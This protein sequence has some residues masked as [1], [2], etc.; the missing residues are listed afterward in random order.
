M[1]ISSDDQF[2]FQRLVTLAPFV[3]IGHAECRDLESRGPGPLAATI[4]TRLKAADSTELCWLALAVLGAYFPEDN[5][6]VALQ[7]SLRL[8]EPGLT[9]RALLGA[10][11]RQQHRLSKPARVVKVVTD[12]VIVDVDFCARYLHNTGIQRVVRQTMRRWLAQ[13]RDITLVAWLPHARAYRYLAPQERER[14]INWGSPAAMEPNSSQDLGDGDDVIIPFRCT[15]IVPEVPQQI[16][17]AP[18]RSLAK[19]SGNRCHLIAYD[20]IPVVSATTVPADETTRFLDY[21]SF[22]KHAHLAVAISEATA[23]EFRG[24]T[25]ALAPQGLEG[26]EVVA[27]SLP[28]ARPDTSGHGPTATM[29]KP[30]VLCVGSIEPRKNQFA[31]L[32]ASEQLWAQGVSF[33]LMFIG[34]GSTQPVAALERAL[35]KARRRGHDVALLSGVADAELE[36]AYRSATLTVFPS[37]HE[38]YGL[39]V[40]ESLAYGVPVV[41]SNFGATAEVAKNGGCVLVD[42]RD[43]AAIAAAMFDILTNESLR[44]E[45]IGGIGALPTR[46]WDDYATAAWTALAHHAGPVSHG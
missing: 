29:D 25:S 2:F 30:I 16:L 3:G 40:A 20:M 44:A 18:L 45:L 33:R 10:L 21:L 6:V 11:V 36:S 1:E 13:G 15:V 17:C 43:D 4:A 7:R 26:P 9:H 41:T 22:V 39:P 23:E 42:P 31:V 38:G 46:D 28:M 34:G 35:A 14:V 8:A 19:N 24:F 37:L 32:A 27:V 5:R 12:S